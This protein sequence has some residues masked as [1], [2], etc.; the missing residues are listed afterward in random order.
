MLSFVSWIEEP[1]W[2]DKDAQVFASRGTGIP[3]Q[4]D[5]H[6]ATAWRTGE[7][8][9]GCSGRLSQSAWKTGPGITTPSGGLGGRLP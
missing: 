9:P 4:W 6:K 8:L 1:A 7:K 3:H 2:A 5:G